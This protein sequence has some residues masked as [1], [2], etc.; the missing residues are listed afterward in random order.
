MRLKNTRGKKNLIGAKLLCGDD[1]LAMNTKWCVKPNGFSNSSTLCDFVSYNKCKKFY[2]FFAFK[3]FSLKSLSHKFT[4]GE[5]KKI[6]IRTEAQNDK[7]ESFQMRT[8]K[9]D[10]FL[11]AG[12]LNKHRRKKRWTKTSLKIWL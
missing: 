2:L 12:C 6:E 10:S 4:L 11:W 7:T 8:D 1:A 9:W 5:T 3:Y